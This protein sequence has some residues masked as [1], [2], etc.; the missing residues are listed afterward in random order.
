MDEQRTDRDQIP[1]V[2]DWAAWKGLD[3]QPSSLWRAMVDS[4]PTTAPFAV[5]GV[6]FYMHGATWLALIA[7]A[8]LVGAILWTNR[9]RD[10]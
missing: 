3:V 9:C 4:A 1:A 7:L 8:L 10:P 5:L 2:P 6:A